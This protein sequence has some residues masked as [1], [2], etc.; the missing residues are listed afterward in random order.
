MRSDTG[1]IILINRD[2][3]NY[4][5]DRPDLALAKAIIEQEGE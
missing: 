2:T 1:K 3:D 5:I 4:I